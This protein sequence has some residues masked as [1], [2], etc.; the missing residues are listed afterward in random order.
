MLALFVEPI[1]VVFSWACG[2][3]TS[4]FVA[5]W[6]IKRRK[7]HHE[8]LQQK[9]LNLGKIIKSRCCLLHSFKNTSLSYRV[10]C[11]CSRSSCSLLSKRH[12]NSKKDSSTVVWG[13]VSSACGL[14]SAVSYLWLYRF[15]S[16]KK[17]HVNGDVTNVD[18]MLQKQPRSRDRRKV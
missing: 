18:V 16:R 12:K 15:R 10:H 9:R 1:R 5:T 3:S 14:V 2:S 13:T 6:R 4:A 7:L 8:K 17:P 11:Y